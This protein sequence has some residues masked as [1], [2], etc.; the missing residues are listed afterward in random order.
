[1]D[2]DLFLTWGR[3]LPTVHLSLPDSVY[4]RLK[5]KA[6]ELGIQVTD[7][8]KIYINLGLQGAL[9]KGNSDAGNEYVLNKLDQ[10]DK[11]LRMALMRLEGKQRELEEMFNYLEA[12]LDYLEDTIQEIIR[13]RKAK[14]AIQEA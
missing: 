3:H 5:E 2:Y 9:A 11:K 10:M 13:E 4:K 12:R 14:S 1:M 8:I 6:A 7:I